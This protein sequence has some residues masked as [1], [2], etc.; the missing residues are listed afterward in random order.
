L[1]GLDKLANV[2]TTIRNFEI[3]MDAVIAAKA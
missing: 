1:F 2:E 3:G